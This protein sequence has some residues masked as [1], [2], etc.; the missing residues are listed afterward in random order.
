MLPVSYQNR[1]NHNNTCCGNKKDKIA[2]STTL[3]KLENLVKCTQSQKNAVESLGN[4][5]EQLSN[6]LQESL[7]TESSNLLN[8]YRNIAIRNMNRYRTITNRK[9]QGKAILYSDIDY[10][11]E[12]YNIQS[13][14]QTFLGSV[15]IYSSWVSDQTLTFNPDGQVVSILTTDDSSRIIANKIVQENIPAS[16][17]NE[18]YIQII[19]T[20]NASNLSFTLNGID[21]V[22]DTDDLP[23]LVT[24]LENLFPNL[25]ISLNSNIITIRNETGDNFILTNFQSND[26]AVAPN[27]ITVELSGENNTSPVS[28]DLVNDDIITTTYYIRGNFIVYNSNNFTITRIPSTNGIF[29]NQVTQSVI[30]NYTPEELINAELLCL[31][32]YENVRIRDRIIIPCGC[33]NTDVITTEYY[34]TLYNFLISLFNELEFINTEEDINK[35]T[36]FIQILSSVQTILSNYEDIISFKLNSYQNIMNDYIKF[37][38]SCNKC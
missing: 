37:I 35:R 7:D 20:G 15:S 2:N 23:A 11:N 13:D 21:I 27:N 22:V 14:S 24:E 3:K 31:L 5:A 25:Q 36:N 10:L 1:K 9:C 32:L 26:A 12:I 33:N 17:H 19:S 16:A 4:I 34:E 38:K 18:A 28:I 8:N 29:I 6:I 30:S